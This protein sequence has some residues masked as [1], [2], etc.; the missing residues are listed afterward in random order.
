MTPER[1]WEVRPIGKVECSYTEKAGTPKQATILERQSGQQQTASIVLFE[2]FGECI[3]DL[4]GFEFIWVIS[5][6]HLN[7]GYRKKITT[8]P[9]GGA[10]IYIPI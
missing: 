4:E 7:K 5:Y 3:Y 6:M 10:A 9:R 2:E 1:R 8:R